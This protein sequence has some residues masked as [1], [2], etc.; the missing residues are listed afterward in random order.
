MAEL[1]QEKY[2]SAARCPGDDTCN[3]WTSAAGS[4]EEK[5]K[6]CIG[7]GQCDGKPPIKGG[8]KEAASVFQKQ[9]VVAQIEGLV[10]RQN[11]LL[12]IGEITFVEE[13]LLIIWREAEAEQERFFKIRTRLIYEAMVS[14]NG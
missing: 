11:A 12:P 6:A 13:R 8:S 10:K 3:R 5:T 1:Y 7:C 9:R 14:Q 2:S 4:F